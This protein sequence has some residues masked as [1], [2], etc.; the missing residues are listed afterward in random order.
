MRVLVFSDL[1]GDRAQLE[2]LMEQ[3]ADYYVAAGDLV[4]WGRG[5]EA[6]G[7]VLRQRAGRVGVLPG[8]HEHERD[9]EAFCT[10]FG[11]E[12][13]RGRVRD[14]GNGWALAGLGHSSPTPFNTPGEY[15]EEEFR[16]R[17]AAF[18]G[19]RADR[20]LLVCHCPPYGTVLDEAAPGRHIGSVAIGEFLEEFQPAY[21]CCGHVHEAWG[22][23]ADLGRTKGINVG[24]AG[25]YVELGD[26][27]RTESTGA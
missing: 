17:L 18:R 27:E 5:L 14:L 4:S 24:R 20:T 3:E 2:R 22:R 7:A 16:S 26:V 23:T 1:H 15:S 8:N 10:T 6:M 21:F 11:L 25:F 19:L 12:A 13:L 9:V